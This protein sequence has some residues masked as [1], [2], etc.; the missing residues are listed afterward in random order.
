MNTNIL[1]TCVTIALASLAVAG[2][3]QT[4]AAPSGV[5]PPTP[6]AKTVVTPVQEGAGALRATLGQSRE[7]VAKP[8]GEIDPFTGQAVGFQ[9]LAHQLKLE[10]ARTAILNERV[11]Q[12]RALEDMEKTGFRT[13]PDRPTQ[14]PGQAGVPV[15]NRPPVE[16]PAPQTQAASRPR[17]VTP[18]AR[19][20]KPAA[21]V[22]REQVVAAPAPIEPR[23]MG[24]TSVAGR[25][26]AMFQQGEKSLLVPENGTLG[27]VHVGDVQGDHVMVNGSQRQVNVGGQEVIVQPTTKQM[28]T[29]LTASPT[30]T[31][32][33]SPAN[34]T[35]DM[36]TLALPGVPAAP[37]VVRGPQPLPSSMP[38]YL[39][40]PP[41]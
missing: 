39:P 4:A 1:T 5:A 6:A 34:P 20:P 22:P 23:L 37:T 29:S 13:V 40:P 10:K 28:A 16:R 3:A 19:A 8:I 24:I 7:L 38:A 21:G 2:H 15:L 27:T 33:A 32:A 41:Q 18:V 30:A 12:V 17:A 26:Y 31:L 35:A 14:A 25:N 36:R 9:N 11:L